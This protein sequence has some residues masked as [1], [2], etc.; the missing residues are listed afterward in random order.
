[1]ILVPLSP[2]LEYAVSGHPMLEVH[3]VLPLLCLA[4]L[5][6]M[7]LQTLKFGVEISNGCCGGVV[8]REELVVPSHL[9]SNPCSYNLVH[10]S[11]LTHSSI[12]FIVN[13]PLSSFLVF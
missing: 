8:G 5:D 13:A 1:M 4:P 3:C 2:G 10:R 9:A 6:S 12:Y 7:A 11:L